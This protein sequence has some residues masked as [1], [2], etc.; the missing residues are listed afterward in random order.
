[1]ITP[2]TAVPTSGAPIDSTTT[3]TTAAPVDSTT[4][5]S[6]GPIAPAALTT[7]AAQTAAI[8]ALDSSSVSPS[9]VSATVSNLI[10]AGLT[11]TA[12][13]DL[14]VSDKVLSSID[15]AQ[16]KSVFAA[17]P[18]SSLSP[19]QIAAVSAAVTNA[20]TEIKNAFESTIDVYGS[21]FDKYVP[22]GSNI[23]V[24]AR[25]TLVAATAA[26][27]SIA[28]AAATGGAAMG[29]SGGSSPT[30]GGSSGDPSG[31]APVGPKPEDS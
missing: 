14:A 5:T 19:E 25:R 10:N 22:V 3:T 16:A 8:A 20:P 30:G 18:V 15:S 1:M 17:I 21:G 9:E 7:P 29:G 6:P 11:G 2:S 23:D 12:A 26:V 13:T 27:A 28:A 31:S 24:S 4:T